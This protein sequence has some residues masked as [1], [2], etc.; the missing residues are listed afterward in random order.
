MTTYLDLPDLLAVIEELEIGPVE[1][2]GLLDAAL[3]RPRSHYFGL[4]AYPTMPLKAAA[5]LDAL[6]NHHGLRDGQKRMAL[7]AT[8]VFLRLNGYTSHMTEDEAH[9]LTLDVAAGLHD[10]KVI[11][12]RLDVALDPDRPAWPST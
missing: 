9:D 4:E 1:D 5:L 12:S 8:L 10:L 2:L 11:A 3:A 6:C 7:T